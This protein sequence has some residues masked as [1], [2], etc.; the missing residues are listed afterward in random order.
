MLPYSSAPSPATQGWYAPPP[1]FVRICASR[2]RWEPLR[3]AI[4][5]ALSAWPFLRMTADSRK[6][7]PGDNDK[8][9][10]AGSGSGKKR[11]AGIADVPSYFSPSQAPRAALPPA[12]S[13]PSERAI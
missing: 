4:A 9:Q 2:C 8:D 5:S 6:D 11:L 12:P 7:C 3:L 1:A 10:Q 13:G